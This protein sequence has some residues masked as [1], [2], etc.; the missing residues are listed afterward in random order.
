MPSP[1]LGGSIDVVVADVG[2]GI[3]CQ[4]HLP[5]KPASFD[6]ELMSLASRSFLVYLDSIGHSAHFSHKRNM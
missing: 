6:V 3:D 5:V 1:V 2:V 4:V